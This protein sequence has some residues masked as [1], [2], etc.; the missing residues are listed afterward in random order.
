ML[1]DEDEKR[2]L[3]DEQMIKVLA[4]EETMNGRAIVRTHVPLIN[5]PHRYQP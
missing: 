3:V 5:C 2:M 1:I 4:D